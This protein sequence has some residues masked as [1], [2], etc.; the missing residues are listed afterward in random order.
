MNILNNVYTCD[1]LDNKLAWAGPTAKK[2]PLFLDGA[3]KHSTQS[4]HAP[5]TL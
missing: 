1:T 5:V 4:T 2:T 3:F